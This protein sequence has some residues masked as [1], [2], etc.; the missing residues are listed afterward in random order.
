MAD[1]NEFRI[2]INKWLFVAAAV[3][4]LGTSI[5]TLIYNYGS[6]DWASMWTGMLGALNRVGLIL[7][8]LGYL[9]PRHRSMRVSWKVFLIGVVALVGIALRPRFAFPLLAILVAVALFLRPRDKAAK[10]KK[11]SRKYRGE[12]TETPESKAETGA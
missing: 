2:T 6:Q 3:G 10:Q 7:A 11:L 4:C 5:G 9:V 1:K 8:A 12:K